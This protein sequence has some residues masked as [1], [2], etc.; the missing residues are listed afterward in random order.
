MGVVYSY[1]GMTWGEE[2][3]GAVPLVNFSPGLFGSGGVLRA[4][5]MFDLFVRQP[6]FLQTLAEAQKR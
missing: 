4:Y 2:E 6:Q 5:Y 3:G 1:M